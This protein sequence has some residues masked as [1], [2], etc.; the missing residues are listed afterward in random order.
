MSVWEFFPDKLNKGEY[1]FKEH[2]FLNSYCGSDSCDTPFEK[3]N[4]GCLYL[5]NQFFGR[6]DLFKSV[7]NSNI[8][9]VDYI[10]IWLSYMLNLKEQQ[11]NDS[12]LPFFYNTTINNDR[13]QKTITD[14]KEYK[15]YK[16]LIDKKKYFLDMNKKIISNFY[17]AFKLLCEM[18]AEFD[19]KTQYCAK[20]SKNAIQFV[21]KYK[22]MNQNS[23]ITS[24]GSYNE[25]LSTLSN[26]YN[27][28]KEYCN[29]KGNKCKD[30]PDL[31]TIEKK[32]NFAQSSEDT[33]SSSSITTRLFTVLSIFGAIAFFLGISYK[34]SLFGF[35][36]RFQK[37]KLKEKIKNIK[38]RINH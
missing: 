30:Y 4:G 16:E 32:Q 6:S 12:N 33:P 34:Y 18:Y 23:D 5:F 21:S 36:K 27:N 9:I 7:A 29:S 8:N 20:C 22:E 11:R 1:E 17:E 19:D 26:D 35:R 15:N 14:V 13:Y 31:L 37:Q 2:N 3:I 38:K 24:N 10:L 25:L 28:F